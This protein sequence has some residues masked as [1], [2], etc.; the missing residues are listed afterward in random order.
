ML[1]A[2]HVDTPL[3]YE[4]LAAAGSM[5]GTAAIMVMD[6]TDCVVDCATR[7]VRFYAHESCGKCTTCREGSWW[8]T[9]VLDRLEH[10]YG[11]PEDLPVMTDLGKNILFRAFCALADGTAS[12][13]NSSLKHFGDEYEE[14][15]RLGR[16]P[17][18]ADHLAEVR[19]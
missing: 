5:L 18:K 4:S 16:C 2:G 19:A 10:G 1:T 11:R 17:L 7:M 3:D 14:H 6:E 8:A 15:V 9:R 13:I 12:V